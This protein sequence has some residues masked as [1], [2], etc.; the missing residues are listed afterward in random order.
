LYVN[1]ESVEIRDCGKNIYKVYVVNG[2]TDLK[3]YFD[4]TFLDEKFTANFCNKI[5]SALNN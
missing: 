4:K 3:K 1:P 2:I 5:S